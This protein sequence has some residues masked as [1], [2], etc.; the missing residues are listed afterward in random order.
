MRGTRAANVAAGR[1]QTTSA[2]LRPAPLATFL[3]ALSRNPWR[4]T[5]SFAPLSPP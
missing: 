1:P 4:M 5:P 3:P 2:C